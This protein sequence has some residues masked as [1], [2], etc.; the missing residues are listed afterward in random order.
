MA[1]TRADRRALDC[2]RMGATDTSEGNGNLPSHP[3]RNSPSFFVTGSVA[4][5]I[6]ANGG[7]VR[8]AELASKTKAKVRN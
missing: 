1:R 8:R 3:A 4:G 5:F 6:R 2:A 7:I